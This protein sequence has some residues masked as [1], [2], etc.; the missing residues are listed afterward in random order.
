VP[1]EREAFWSRMRLIHGG[2]TRVMMARLVAGALFLTGAVGDGAAAAPAPVKP[3]AL[4]GTRVVAF[5]PGRFAGTL[6][7]HSRTSCSQ[8]YETIDSRGTVTLDLAGDGTATGCRS[9]DYRSAMFPSPLSRRTRVSSDGT[10]IVLRDQ[11]GMRG[12]WHRDGDVIVIDLAPDAAVCPAQPES[13]SDAPAAWRLRCVAVEPEGKSSRLGA[14]ALA[15]QWADRGNTAP[16]AAETWAQPGYVTSSVG[17]GQWMFLGRAPGLT[18][19][20]QSV[21]IGLTPKMEVVWKTGTA[22]I[23]SGSAQ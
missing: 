14:P 23:P 22:P 9:R 7:H 21:G 11:H 18:L 13:T 8:S 17:E 15:C 2:A 10:E 5:T 19:E 16:T 4:P 12:R 20:E 6:Q 1:L 3:P